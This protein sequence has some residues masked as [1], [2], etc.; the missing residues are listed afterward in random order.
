M[1]KNLQIEGP[2]R[3][4][5][6]SRDPAGVRR[7]CAVALAEISKM[8]ATHLV[9]LRHASRMC[10]EAQG[11]GLDDGAMRQCSYTGLITWR[12][13]SSALFEVAGGGMQALAHEYA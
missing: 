6:Q 12:Q 9:A 2:G 11:D 13:S 10:A 1:A 7:H 4:Q 5:H 8:E 3:T